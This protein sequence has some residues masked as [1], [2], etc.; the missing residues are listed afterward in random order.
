[1]SSNCSAAVAVEP[2]YYVD[3]YDFIHE[4][5][6]WDLEFYK[7]ALPG[8]KSI[9]ELGCGTGRLLL[10]LAGAGFEMTGLDIS[11]PMLDGARAKLR[12]QQGPWP[13]LH[14]AD[15]RNFKL[16]ARF[17][18]ATIPF[19]TFL[20]LHQRADQLSCLRSV[21]EHLVDGGLL[22]LDVFN[23]DWIL[24][25]RQQSALYHEFSKLRQESGVLFSYYSSFVCDN[26]FLYWNQF[27]E[28]VDPSGGV[29]KHFRQMQLARLTRAALEELCVEAGFR[30]EAVYGWYDGQL[31]TENHNNLIFAL[32]KPGES[33]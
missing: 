6:A 30:I 3:N 25:A 14:C 7:A 17:D 24:R 22:L 32:R 21:H 28:D 8:G 4:T 33:L 19:N 26:S 12:K 11:E 2:N 31:A 23:P 20:H 9:L 29:H 13:E 1:M 18:A 15:M 5:L 10:P 27:F 16:A